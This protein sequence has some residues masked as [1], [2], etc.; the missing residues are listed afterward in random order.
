MFD[1]RITLLTGGILHIREVR[2][3][4]LGV[5]SC[6]LSNRVANFTSQ[7]YPLTTSGTFQSFA[8]SFSYIIKEIIW[9]I[10]Q[11]EPFTE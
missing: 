2:Q 8:H 6:F 1:F 11:I 9:I 5:Y 4:D 3:S 7:T 10:V